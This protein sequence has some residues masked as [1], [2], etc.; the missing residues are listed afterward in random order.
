ML[1]STAVKLFIGTFYFVGS[2]LLL[3]GF[4]WIIP[5]KVVT[6]HLHIPVHFDNVT[7]K[8]DR[9]INKDVPNVPVFGSKYGDGIQLCIVG[10]VFI[11]IASVSDFALVHCPA[12][13]AMG[14]AGALRVVG[15]ILPIFGAGLIMWG[16]IAFLPSNQ[17]LLWNGQMDRKNQP[18]PEMFNMKPSDFGN[19]L[20]KIG[21]VIY[22][23]GA[24]LGIVGA[25]K[26]IKAYQDGHSNSDNTLGLQLSIPAFFL[27]VCTSTAYFINGCMSASL[28]VQAGWLRMGGT[29]CLFM[30]VLILCLATVLEIFDIDCGGARRPALLRD[31]ENSLQ[32]V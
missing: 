15:N 6:L 17:G 31:N 9:F 25:V 4:R 5:E 19:L 12:A 18:A 14:K 23:L 2:I 24:I 11:I 30:A 22:A 1:K 29:I 26:G 27:F 10:M 20:F 3:P 32:T 7:H 16:C 8:P 28:A 13:M 21:S